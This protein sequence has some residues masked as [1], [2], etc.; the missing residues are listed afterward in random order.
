MNQ[1][2]D[3]E[4]SRIRAKFR[5]DTSENNFPWAPAMG[6]IASYRIIKR[7]RGHPLLVILTL[8]IRVPVQRSQAEAHNV[9]HNGSTSHR[10]RN[11]GHNYI[12]P[13][14]QVINLAPRRRLQLPLPKIAIYYSLP[15][16]PV[17]SRLHVKDPPT[18][19]PTATT[20]SSRFMIHHP[21]RNSRHK[22]LLRHRT[23]AILPPAQGRTR[24]QPSIHTWQC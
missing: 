24:S 18:R 1:R 15:K 19:T 11:Y 20:S 7:L 3:I 5:H 22:L 13:T 8:L 12:L 4:C 17:R 10:P 14:H 6:T 2:K 16:S 21:R 23:P 9:H